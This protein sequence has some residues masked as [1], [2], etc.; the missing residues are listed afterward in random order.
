MS[1][2]DAYDRAIRSAAALE[3]SDGN[4]GWSAKSSRQEEGHPDRPRS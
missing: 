3:T 2:V 1:K 4:A